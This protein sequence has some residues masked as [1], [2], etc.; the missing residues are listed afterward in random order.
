MPSILD[1]WSE[2]DR[3]RG[4]VNGLKELG[5]SI[6]IR[7]DQNG[8]VVIVVNGENLVFGVNSGVL[9]KESKKVGEEFYKIARSKGFFKHQEGYNQG[10]AQVFTHAE[11]HSL[12]GAYRRNGGNLSEEVTMH[13]DRTSCGNCQ[14]QL[15]TIMEVL[16]VKR[17]GVIA[18]KSSNGI[19]HKQID[20]GKYLKTYRGKE[21]TI[22]VKSTLANGRSFG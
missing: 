3:L 19:L 15:T 18:K 22:D 14:N 21:K 5:D 12:M 10:T 4:K 11:T 16:G 7:G 17:L 1:P 13:V 9:S 2:I 8:T 20:T 6:P